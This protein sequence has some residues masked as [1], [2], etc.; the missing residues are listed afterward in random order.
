MTIVFLVCSIPLVVRIFVNQLYG[1]AHVSAGG[2]PDY[3]SDL[4]AIRNPLAT[5]LAVKNIQRA[6]GGTM[7]SLK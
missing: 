1:P 6:V 4:L 2:K 5:L 3:R 7:A